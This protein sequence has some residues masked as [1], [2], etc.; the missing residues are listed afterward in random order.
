MYV[1]R[2]QTSFLN[3][4][5]WL[6][7][8][9][10]KQFVTSKN[11]FSSNGLLPVVL[12][13]YDI[14]IVVWAP[15]KSSN[16]FKRSARDCKYVWT[17]YNYQLKGQRSNMT[18]LTLQIQS[19][20]PLHSRPHQPLECSQ[21]RVEMMTHR[22]PYLKITYINKNNASHTDTLVAT[23]NLSAQLRNC[24]TFCD[25]KFQYC[26]ISCSWKMRAKMKN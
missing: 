2:G 7:Y 4:R 1:H 19:Q 25:Y 9:E 13:S 11:F 14:T 17:G 26:S 20:Q 5:T 10:T 23:M 12:S 6:G 8:S 21:E 24:H 22:I 16:V 18:H 15:L 3:W